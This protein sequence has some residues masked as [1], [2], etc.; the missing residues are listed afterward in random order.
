MWVQLLLIRCCF[1]FW[2]F[3]IV[4]I[5]YYCLAFLP[6][7]MYVRFCVVGLIPNGLKQKKPERT[8]GGGV[9]ISFHGQLMS[10]FP[11]KIVFDVSVCC[12]VVITAWIYFQKKWGGGGG[13]VGVGILFDTFFGYLYYPQFS[14]LL[15]SPLWGSFSLKPASLTLKFCMV[16]MF[17]M[18][19]VSFG[20]LMIGKQGR[21]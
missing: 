6:S 20:Q 18:S 14:R 15:Q 17:L 3:L 19:F 9:Q 21:C 4:F 16:Q 11:E 5:I 7:F 2:L 12:E 10:N 1:Q 13:G 8:R